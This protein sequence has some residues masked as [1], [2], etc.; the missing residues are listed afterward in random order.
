MLVKFLSS[1]LLVRQPIKPR[2]VGG[3]GGKFFSLLGPLVGLPASPPEPLLTHLR[4]KIESEFTR[5]LVTW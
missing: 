1:K 3:Q 5:P 4:A 2:P